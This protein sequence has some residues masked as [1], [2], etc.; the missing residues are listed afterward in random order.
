MNEEYEYETVG[1]QRHPIG[2][3]GRVFQIKDA[4]Y[5]NGRIGNHW[6]K[7]RL[8][9]DDRVMCLQHSGD[10]YQTYTLLDEMRSFV[11]QFGAYTLPKDWIVE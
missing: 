6:M 4:N 5:A 10:C 1:R 8:V 11:A 2:V 3:V 7:G 9:K